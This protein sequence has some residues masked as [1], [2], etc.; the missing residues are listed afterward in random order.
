M[1]L[2]KGDPCPLP[3]CGKPILGREM[4]AKH[5]AVWQKYG[6]P[7]HPVRRYVR[8]GSECSHEGCDEK[9]K[10]LGMCEKHAKRTIKHGESTEPRERRFW[11]KVDKNGPIPE[12]RPELGPCWVWT[13]YIDPKTGYGQF[14]GKEGTRLP[15]R[16]AYEYVVGPIPKGLHV[17][18]LCK[19]RACVNAEGHL[20]PVT[21]R[22]NL[23]RGNQGAF[24][25]YVPETIP[26]KP[27]VEKP[28]ICVEP[29]CDRPPAKDGRC[30][31]CYRKWLK[32]PNRP[33]PPTVE[34]RF[35]SKVDKGGPIP[36]HKPEL[37]RCWVWT[38]GIN[39]RTGYGRFTVK[40]GEMMDA[41]RYSYLLS[42]GSIPEGYD[43]H[44]ECHLR[45]CLNP[46]HL[47]ATTRSENMALRKK[48]R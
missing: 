13:G 42:Y 34:E 39:G 48:R 26:E 36:E 38:A 27:K 10:R 35:W 6:D 40:H 31:P 30:R 44:H 14:G 23:E 3:D 8:Q 17:D 15:H 7:L 37:G 19:N 9:P 28:S 47:R 22:E 5:Y 21:P 1:A 41:H 2:R 43:V 12:G 32:N 11:A 46:S 20:E 29:D 18:H 24:W 16:I 4:C 25:G 45:R 33:K